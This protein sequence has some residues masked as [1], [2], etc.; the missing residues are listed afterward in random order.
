MLRVRDSY[1]PMNISPLKGQMFNQNDDDARGSVLVGVGNNERL[2]EFFVAPRQHQSGSLSVRPL[3]HYTPL[4]PKVLGR[5]PL[6]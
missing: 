5:V 3:Q 2:V 1:S 4:S 6:R